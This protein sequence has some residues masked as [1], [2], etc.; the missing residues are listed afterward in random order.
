MDLCFGAICLFG[1]MA[2]P[3][4]LKITDNDALSVGVFLMISV[5]VPI[6]YFSGLCC[7][8]MKGTISC[9]MLGLQVVD[10]YGDELSFPRSVIRFGGQFISI[11]AWP[12]GI[13]SLLLIATRRRPLHDLIAGSTVLLRF[14]TP[15]A[16]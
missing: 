1:G 13:I 16:T 6:G 4:F 7:S 15:A 5:G 12:I 2:V 3:G 11:V 10:K 9:Y 14:R 8:P